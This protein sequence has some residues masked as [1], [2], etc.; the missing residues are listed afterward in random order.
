MVSRISRSHFHQWQNIFVPNIKLFW[1]I[2]PSIWL[3]YVNF[4][5]I[6]I[7]FSSKAATE[8]M[9]WTNDSNHRTRTHNTFFPRPLWLSHT[10]H[11][12]SSLPGGLSRAP[13]KPYYFL[14]MDRSSNKELYR[15]PLF[16]PP[17]KQISSH[18]HHS[19]FWCN[20]GCFGAVL[21]V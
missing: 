7:S 1:S 13:R 6:S 9:W 18:R 8:D 5:F 10:T 2:N 17:A 21:N 12:C 11:T 3:R 16:N 4:K 20:T 19:R 15:T 14:V